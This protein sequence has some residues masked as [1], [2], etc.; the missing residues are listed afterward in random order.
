MRFEV[1]P[2]KL[3]SREIHFTANCNIIR[4]IKQHL[5]YNI[6]LI[7]QESRKKYIQYII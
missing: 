7:S 6:S 4:Q 2:K 5:N 3:T 1:A